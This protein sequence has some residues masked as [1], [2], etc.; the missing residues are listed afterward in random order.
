[1]FGTKATRLHRI[2]V[3][4][5]VFIILAILI[6]RKVAGEKF[7]DCLSFDLHKKQTGL[8]IAKTVNLG[9]TAHLPC[10]FW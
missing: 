8:H 9:E 1:M 3:I 6:R 10:H 5:I 2:E 7:S 4:G